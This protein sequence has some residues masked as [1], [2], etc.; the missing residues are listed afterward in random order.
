MNIVK[1]KPAAKEGMKTRNENRL[2]A[3]HRIIPNLITLT[4]MAAG[5]TS[6]QLALSD[7]WDKAVIA[8]LIALVLDGMDGATAR[9]L[10]ATSDFGVVLDTLSDFLAFGIAPAIILYTWILEESGRIGWV[11][12]IFYV[13]A[14]A[15]RLARFSVEQKKLPKW[16]K[17]FFFGIPSPAGA[18]LALLP[19]ILWFHYPEFFRQFAF[20][21]PLVGMWIIAVAGMMVSRIPTFS[22]KMVTIP[23][24]MGM[25]VMAC[26]SLLL[27]ALVN[28]PWPTLTVVGL[29][30]MASI[31]FSIAYFRKQKRNHRDDEE[32]PG[33]QL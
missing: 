16:Q 5:L 18:G 32:E 33:L 20:A 10:K 27:A 14:T 26:M 3:F 11:A 24:K 1:L 22:L 25:T 13:S 9:F 19:L 12:M 23:A 7:Q 17:G 30:Y 29:V 31:P 8:V 21:S 2:I 4:A 6:L 28:M 15:L